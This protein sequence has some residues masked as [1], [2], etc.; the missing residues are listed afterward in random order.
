MVHLLYTTLE[1]CTKYGMVSSERILGI[2][3]IHKFRSRPVLHFNEDSYSTCSGIYQAYEAF[4]DRH[5]RSTQF[6]HKSFEA[7]P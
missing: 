1:V 2:L 3:C 5:R 7:L 6:C 4:P